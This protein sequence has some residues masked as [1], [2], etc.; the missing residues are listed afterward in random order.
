MSRDTA[1]SQIRMVDATSSGDN[2]SWAVRLATLSLDGVGWGLTLG[3]YRQ[4]IG[5]YS[6][7]VLVL[8]LLA[9]IDLHFAPR[10]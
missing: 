1:S 4:C 10:G 7:T 5:P 9:V 2:S 6:G 8:Q 3:P